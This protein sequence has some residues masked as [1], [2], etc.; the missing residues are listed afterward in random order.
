M[1]LICRDGLDLVESD[2]VVSLA[3]VLPLHDFDFFD[4][5]V[6]LGSDSAGFGI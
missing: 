4:V 1:E 6:K 2:L 5:K 3:Q